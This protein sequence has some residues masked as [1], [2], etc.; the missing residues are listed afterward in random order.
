M[1][2]WNNSRPSTQ[3]PVLHTMLLK[4]RLHGSCLDT[5]K[6]TIG[7]FVLATEIIL[8][9]VMLFLTNYCLHLML[10][11]LWSQWFGFSCSQNISGSYLFY[12]RGNLGIQKSATHNLGCKGRWESW[13]GSTPSLSESILCC[14]RCARCSLCSLSGHTTTLN[15]KILWNT[16]HPCFPRVLPSSLDSQRSHRSWWKCFCCC[17]LQDC[18]VGYACCCGKST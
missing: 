15:K 3:K 13:V 16:G 2:G 8:M 6:E 11:I 18:P 10:N 1:V 12:S 9:V 17:H 5:S 14:E 7:Y 4:Q